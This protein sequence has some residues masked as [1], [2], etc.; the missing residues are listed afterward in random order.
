MKAPY[1]YF[2]LFIIALIEG[3]EYLAIENGFK[4]LFKLI[5]T[6]RDH[7]I[8]SGSIVLIATTPD[9]WKKEEWVS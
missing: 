3:L 1:S 8:L 6:I 9:G 4:R 7:A 2:K 5:S